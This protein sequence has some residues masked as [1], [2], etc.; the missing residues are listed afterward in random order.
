MSFA[1]SSHMS[2]RVARSSHM[3]NLVI[4]YIELSGEH[5]MEVPATLPPLSSGGLGSE[6]ALAL[7]SLHGPV[8][9]F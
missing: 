8:S 1:R 7:G 5:L 9:Q 3:T 6:M 2:E 4:C